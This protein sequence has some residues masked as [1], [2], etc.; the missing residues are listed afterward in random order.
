MELPRES[1][2]Q[3]LKLFAGLTNL[4]LLVIGGDGTVAWILSCLDSLKVQGL[5]LHK[6]RVPCLNPV[7]VQGSR[8][9]CLRIAESNMLGLLTM[10]QTSVVLA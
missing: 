6:H 5:L 3:A 2:E 1:P 4:R 8:S 9:S 7:N 10:Y